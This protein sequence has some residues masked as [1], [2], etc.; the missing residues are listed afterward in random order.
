VLATSRDGQTF[1]RA[2]LVRGEPTHMSFEGRHKL[3][4]W[5]YPNALVVGDHLLVAY[6]A[7]KEDVGVTKIPLSALR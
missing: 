3:D 7:N 4:G 2:W 5:Q 1:D 6:S